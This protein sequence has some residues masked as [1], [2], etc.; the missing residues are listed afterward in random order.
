MNTQSQTQTAVATSSDYFDS[1]LYARAYLNEIKVIPSRKKRGE[2]V[3]CYQCLDRRSW[4]RWSKDLH[5]H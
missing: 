5:H 4:Q 3:L 2:G 1:V